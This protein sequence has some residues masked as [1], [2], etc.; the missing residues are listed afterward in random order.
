LRYLDHVR[1]ARRQARTATS[2][3][4]ARANRKPLTRACRTERVRRRER[5]RRPAS[6]TLQ[7]G[8]SRLQVRYLWD[9]RTE[10]YHRIIGVERGS[11]PWPDSFDRLV[12]RLNR[13]SV[14]LWVFGVLRRQLGQLAMLRIAHRSEPCPTSPV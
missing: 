6:V 5:C 8:A 1:S 7:T 12:I 13:S 11:G 14:E 4:D 3:R 10:P 2:S 9:A